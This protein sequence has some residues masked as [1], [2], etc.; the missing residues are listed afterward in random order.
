VRTGIDGKPLF[1]QLL[2]T[3]EG[4]VGVESKILNGPEVH[5]ENPQ[6]I[7]PIRLDRGGSLSGVVVDHKG[8]P[9]V[10][11]SVIAIYYARPGQPGP[12]QS[13]K[14][15]GKGRFAIRELPRGVIQLSV[16]HGQL[17][18]SLAFLADGSLDEARVQLPEVEFVADFAKMPAQPPAPPAVGQPAPELNVG[19]WSDHRERTL[20]T[21][22]GKVIVLYF[23]GVGFPPSTWLL[24]ALGKLSREYE[25]R[26]VV[27]LAVNNAER[28]RDHVEIQARKVLAFKGAPLVFAIDQTRVAHHARG[29]TADRYGQKTAPPFVV[30]IDRSGRIA[31]HSENATGDGDIGA[32]VRQLSTNS[33]AVTEEQVNERTERAIGQEIERALNQKD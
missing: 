32:V 29:V 21:E 19:P 9:V 10:G 27:F 7:A 17:H 14:T 1:V 20:V 25:P 3:K 13:V 11:A 2:V 24:P 30:V 31:F 8:Q 18:K 12:R 16:F 6:V 5:P 33:A 4:Y 15:D 28:D 22:R 26:G 23:W